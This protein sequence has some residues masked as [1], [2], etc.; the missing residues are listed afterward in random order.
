VQAQLVAANQQVVEEQQDNAALTSQLADLQAT[1]DAYKASHPDQPPAQPQTV[2]KYSAYAGPIIK[3]QYD[4]PATMNNRVAT[5]YGVPALPYERIYSEGKIANLALASPSPVV[6]I[7]YK[8]VPALGAASGPNQATV[9]ALT[10]EFLAMKAKPTRSFHVS[11]DHEIDNKVKQGTYDVATYKR[12]VAVFKGILDQVAAPN[13][14]HSVCYMGW[15]FSQATSNV[16][17]PSNLWVDGAFDRVALDPY[18]TGDLKSVTAAFDPSWTWAEDKGVPVDVWEVGFY[19][20]GTQPLYTEDQVSQRVAQIAAYWKGKAENVL[21]FEANKSDGNNLLE[22]H[23][24]GLS[25]W[26]SAVQ[27]KFG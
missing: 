6:G 16:W 12:A 27:G 10:A 25:I 2:T 13:I 1:F 21:W 17:H 9:A 15:S 4:A 26:S 14:E 19:T 23:A 22:G 18:W 11:I 5:A 7:S 8:Q 24:N 3:D 20:S